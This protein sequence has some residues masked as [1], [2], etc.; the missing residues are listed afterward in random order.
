M[1]ASSLTSDITFHAE[2]ATLLRFI[3]PG[4]C[5]RL[6]GAE[7]RLDPLQLAGPPHHACAPRRP[8]LYG[9]AAGLHGPDKGRGGGDGFIRFH[10]SR[11]RIFTAVFDL[12]RN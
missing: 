7:D 11:L 9:P 6:A 5:R 2:H 8:R 4:R 12:A 3:L 10:F 1:I